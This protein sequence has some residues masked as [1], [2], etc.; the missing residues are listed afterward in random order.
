MSGCVLNLSSEQ[1]ARDVL[2]AADCTI[3]EHVQGAY[4]ALLSPGGAFASVLTLLLTLYVALYGYRLLLGQSSLSMNEI[5]PHFIKIGVVI[6]LATS[7]ASYQTLV[8]DLLFGGPEQVANVVIASAQG[9]SVDIFGELQRL[10]NQMTQA[11]GDRWQQRSGETSRFIFSTPQFAA[12]GL[13]ASSFL[14]MLSTVGVLIVVRIILALLL[15]IGPLFIAMALFAPTRTLFFGWLKTSVRFA[16]IPLFVVL[17]AALMVSV[18]TPFV[19]ELDSLSAQQAS[20][21][22]ANPATAGAGVPEVGADNGPVLAIMLIILVFIALLTQAGR[23]ASGL[24]SGLGSNSLSNMRLPFFADN[25]NPLALQGPQRTD[26]AFAASRVEQVLQTLAPTAE[27]RTAQTPGVAGAASVVTTNRTIIQTAAA[28]QSF[29][30][31]D[32]T[33]RLGQSSRRFDLRERRSAAATPSIA[34]SLPIK[35]G[36]I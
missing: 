13:W 36:T 30:S 28:P 18:L 10:F 12:L 31:A 26:P 1:L 35:A 21:L 14:M 33:S 8:F 22:V 11:A 5:V 3:V 6:A 19:A 23:L 17:L 34:A 15:A 24:S 20:D 2:A 16:F 32:Y 7:W 9:G 25:A 4:E 27:R 29:G